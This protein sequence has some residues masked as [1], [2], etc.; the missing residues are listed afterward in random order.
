MDSLF[1]CACSRYAE[2]PAASLPEVAVVGRSNCGKSS[3]INA[4]VER[5]GLARTSSTP[6]RTQ[7]IVVFRAHMLGRALH[8]VD[9]PGYG[10]AKV[11]RPVRESWAELVGSYIDQR[12]SLHLM[13]LLMDVR[14]APAQEETDLLRWAR[15]RGLA[16]IVALTKGDKLSKA[17]QRPALM[18]ARGALELAEAPD[19]VSVKDR[20]SVARLRSRLV[21][22]LPAAPATEPRDNVTATQTANEGSVEPMPGGRR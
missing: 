2:L 14:R 16:V 9:L 6:G 17:Q 7:Q 22:H 10:F 3:L 21:E 19:L 20:A 13:L 4:L 12:S 8:L 11:P 15:E 18:R 5:K 1:L